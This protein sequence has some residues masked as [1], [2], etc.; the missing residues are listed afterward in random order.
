MPDFRRSLNQNLSLSLN[1]KMIRP[2]LT[3]LQLK[4]GTQ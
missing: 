2:K 3:E 4:P 1:L